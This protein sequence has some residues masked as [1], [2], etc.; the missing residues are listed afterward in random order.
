MFIKNKFSLLSGLAD[1][2]FP[3]R[4]PACGVLLEKIPDA[5]PELCHVCSIALITCESPLCGRCGLPYPGLEGPDHDCPEC[6]ESPPPFEAARSA[7]LYGGS[8]HD[9][10]T[11]FKYGKR[12]HSGEALCRL[13]MDGGLHLK[14]SEGCDVVVPVPLHPLRLLKR[15]FNQSA[16]I[17]VIV[18]RSVSLPCDGRILSRVRRSAPQAGLSRKERESNLKGAFSVKRPGRVRGKTVLLVDDVLTTGA[19]A[20][21]CSRVLLDAGAKA[22]RVFTLA[23]TE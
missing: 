19:T 1:L 8:A 17:A 13:A 20:R 16:V 10:I 15:G 14:A 5:G 11:S 9:G 3:P 2:V 12:I 22:V 18:A 21:E 4:C 6:M 7:F 23:R